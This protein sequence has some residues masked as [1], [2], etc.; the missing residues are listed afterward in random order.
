MYYRCLLLRFQFKDDIKAARNSATQV[1]TQY[2]EEPKTSQRRERLE[3]KSEN[4]L[5]SFALISS[6][7]R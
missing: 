6:I 5:P 7:T 2:I 1:Y 4:Y 3:M